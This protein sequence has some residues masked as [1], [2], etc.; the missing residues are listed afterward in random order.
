[1]Y[2]WQCYY[3]RLYFK[4]WQ[5]YICFKNIGLYFVVCD[6]YNI[7]MIMNVN[8]YLW[9]III[10]HQAFHIANDSSKSS[11]SKYWGGLLGLRQKGLLLSYAIGISK[12]SRKKREGLAIKKKIPF[13]G[14]FFYLLKKFRLSLSSRGVGAGG[15]ALMVL[16]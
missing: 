4:H 14:I 10:I 3:I 8:F 11:P 12:G 9:H 5:S 16:P 1:M 6:S 13:S 15:K 2:P 7:A